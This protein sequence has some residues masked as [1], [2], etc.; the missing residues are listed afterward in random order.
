MK[1]LK[2]IISI[3]LLL[4]SKSAFSATYDG[5][6]PNEITNPFGIMGSGFIIMPVPVNVADA[7][8]LAQFDVA[9]R[10]LKSLV[11]SPVNPA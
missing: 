1:R 5:K 8:L 4:S 9:E 10:K 11:V 6:D 2:I 3:F 7:K